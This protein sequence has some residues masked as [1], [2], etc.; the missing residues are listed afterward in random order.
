MNNKDYLRL[1]PF[2]KPY[3]FVDELLELDEHHAVA[4]Y[5]FRTDEFFYEG[6][7][8]DRPVTPGAM[9]GEAAAQVVLAL[10]LFLAKVKNKEDLKPFFLSSSELRFKRIVLPGDT[11]LIDV[12]KEYF[13]FGK[14][15]ARIQ[16][17]DPEGARICQGAISG[18]IPLDN[19]Q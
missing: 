8:P 12:R 11:I 3:R 6:H 9:L 18:L 7:F 2:E 16:I 10:G 1:L 14:L 4:R 17:N 5:T 13:R 15:K 19:E